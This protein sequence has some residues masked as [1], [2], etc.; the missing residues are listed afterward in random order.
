MV[1]KLCAEVNVLLA[2]IATQLA[3]D[4]DTAYFGGLSN[5]QLLHG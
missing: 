2:L 3:I 1:C 4:S 5:Y